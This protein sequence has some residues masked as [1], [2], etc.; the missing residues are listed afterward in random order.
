M[1]GFQGMGLL[2][3]VLCAWLSVAHG[4]HATAPARV[5]PPRHPSC[6]G[7][8]VARRDARRADRRLVVTASSRGQ[9]DKMAYLNKPEFG[10]IDVAW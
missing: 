7:L 10:E 4:L 3:V 9:F 5:L 2:V 6:H 8:L 1:G